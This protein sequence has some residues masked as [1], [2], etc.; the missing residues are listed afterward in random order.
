[1]LTIMMRSEA[2]PMLP[3]K[4]PLGEK[5]SSP[6]MLSPTHQQKVVAL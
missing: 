1:M 3:E 5:K 4:K 2:D 6:L